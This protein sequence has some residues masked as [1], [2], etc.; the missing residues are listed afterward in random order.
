MKSLFLETTWTR[1]ARHTCSRDEKLLSRVKNSDCLSQ[2]NEKKKNQ[3][4]AFPHVKKSFSLIYFSSAEDS[5]P[6]KP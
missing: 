1:K 6:K 3:P 4:L 2:P 5:V